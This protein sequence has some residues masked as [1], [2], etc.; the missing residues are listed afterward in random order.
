VNPT[1]QSAL[2]TGA[3]RRIGR[4]IAA[5]LAAEGFSVALHASARSL[6]AAQELARELTGSGGKT[7]V[8]CADLSDGEAPARLIAEAQAVL[9]PLSL[10]VNNAS[11][12]E[13][14][15]PDTIDPARWDRH[16]AVNLR[17]P[18]L[19]SAEFA[20][21]AAGRE[22]SIV[23]IVDQRVLRLTPRYFSYTLAKSALW[24]A[25]QTMAQAYAPH[26]R[27]NAVGPGP[28]LPNQNEGHEG[29]AQEAASVPL[30]H[31]VAPEEI[32]EAVLYLA[33]ARSVTGQMIC[34]DSGQHIAWK[35]PDAMV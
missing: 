14:D 6:N 24:T 11:I 1:T 30:E 18:V 2:V 5:R 29:F 34:V 28:V 15:A 4:A 19:L 21:C 26:I 33:H 16:F 9:G 31:A 17:A 13:P 35:T 25:T 27:V 22:A 10:L 23:N 12:F 32:A 8:L 20:R 3:P 7:H